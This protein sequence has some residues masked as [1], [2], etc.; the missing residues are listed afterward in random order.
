[1]PFTGPRLGSASLLTQLIPRGCPS[2]SKIASDTMVALF[3]E[4][5]KQVCDACGSSHL[6]K[7]L[8]ARTLALL[9]I[10]MPLEVAV[11]DALVAAR[12]IHLDLAQPRLSAGRT[13]LTHVRGQVDPECEGPLARIAYND[14]STATRTLLD[15]AAE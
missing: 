7:W 9:T 2:L 4:S 15:A 3:Q 12:A 11:D 13:T 5:H 14:P 6:L 1:M 8:H 10:T